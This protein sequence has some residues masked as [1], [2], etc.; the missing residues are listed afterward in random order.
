[1]WRAAALGAAL[2]ALAAD[3]VAADQEFLWAKAGA[4]DAAVSAD[5]KT[6]E[7]EARRL[8]PP[9]QQRP[10]VVVA[11]GV[12]AAAAAGL[13]AMLLE[14]YITRHEVPAVIGEGVAHRCMRRG[15]YVW[16]PLE[17]EEADALKH[18]HKERAAW[19]DKFYAGDLAERIGSAGALSVPPL[20]RGQAEALTFDGL[21][22]DPTHLVVAKGVVGDGGAVAVGTVTL[23]RTARLKQAGAITEPLAG[24]V[25][26]GA[27]FYEVYGPAVYNRD[28]TYWC[29]PFHFSSLVGPRTRVACLT[30]SDTGYEL[31]S[32]PYGPPFG[33]AP[34]LPEGEVDP[35][36]GDFILA[37][38]D[39]PL[40][41]PFKFSITASYLNFYDVS[42]EAAAVVGGRKVV[43]WRLPL[44]Y[45]KD[46]TV[47][48]PLWTHTLVLHR[49]LGAGVRA[50]LRPGGDGE[51]LLDVKA[52]D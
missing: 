5:L 4:T 14:A 27:V 22:L 12:G 10:G 15:G 7:A 16:L 19:V 32:A 33:G 41:G 50:E 39:E 47:V 43:F 34:Q 44:A 29:G 2:A 6:C 28:E 17:P 26:A 13:T 23:A 49:V 24:T 18:A 31:W 42:V 46:G 25:D 20:P 51:G 37:P 9:I 35:Q 38:S 30:N 21:R 3:A 45:A 1:M 52:A 48:I 8:A 36:A 11:G 40:I